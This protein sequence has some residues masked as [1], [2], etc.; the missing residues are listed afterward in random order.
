MKEVVVF[1]GPTIR[2]D[3]AAVELDAQ[4]LPPVA[5]GDVYR[6]SRY[7]PRAIGIIDGYF[8]SVPAVW[9]K[10]ILWAM[11]QG[12][13]VFGAAS[14]GAL[15]AAELASFG[16]VGVGW[17][18]E[19]YRDGRLEDDDEVAVAHVAEP[20]M[21]YRACSEAMV[22]IRRTLA[23]AAVLGIL[24]PD[25][26][27][28]LE[29]IAK[30]LNYVNRIYPSILRAGRDQGLP[31]QELAE[32]GD[33]VLEGS[34]DQKRDDAR[35]M[36]RYLRVWLE[37]DP[38]PKSVGYQFE[39]TATWDRCVAQTD[40]V[41]W[42]DAWTR[43][44]QDQDVL[45]EARLLPELWKCVRLRALVR[46]LAGSEA[47]RLGLVVDEDALAN[48]VLSFRCNRGLW[49]P[50]DLESWLRA[51]ELTQ[52]ALLS[53]LREDIHGQQVE[54]LAARYMKRTTVDELRLA[55]HYAD[56]ASRAVAKRQV[57][58]GSP[59][60]SF[61]SARCTAA[62]DW[63]EVHRLGEPMGDLAERAHLLDFDGA[64]DLMRAVL[65]EYLYTTSRPVQDSSTE[66][67]RPQ[68]ETAPIPGP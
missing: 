20:E 5:Q 21:G 34:V 12:I 16:M 36:L 67:C 31:K 59:S 40:L 7:H 1:V 65:A 48:A 38:A 11:S 24:S 28:G 9:H 43:S 37:S 60:A 17:I 50:E 64:D 61:D 33:W 55:G 57:D 25:T 47:R 8:D 4:Y 23:A 27:F 14:M 22:N 13:H 15:R 51:N 26:R 29:A 19:A 41:E 2:P 46:L 3:E 35:S 39:Y 42:T 18:F 49:E 53:L 6:V 62:I 66:I 63:F 30:K 10:E 32:F 68:S 58:R 45:D 44:A 52:E 54:R 56:L